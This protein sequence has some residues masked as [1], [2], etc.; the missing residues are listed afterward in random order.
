VLDLSGN[1]AEWTQ[2]RYGPYSMAAA[3]N[4]LGAES[5]SPRVVRGGSWRDDASAAVRATH[6]RAVDPTTGN[7]EIGF[8]CVRPSLAAR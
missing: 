3:H 1:V 4:P 8:R 5:G 2:D 7:E 6:R